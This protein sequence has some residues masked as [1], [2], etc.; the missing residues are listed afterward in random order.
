MAH[1]HERGVSRD[2][3]AAAAGQRMKDTRMLPHFQPEPGLTFEHTAV[4]LPRG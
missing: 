2:E 1:T 4:L 3:C